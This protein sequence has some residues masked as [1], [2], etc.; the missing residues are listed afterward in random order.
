MKVLVTGA[1]GYIGGQI[2]LTC[3]DRGY[4]VIG[5]DWA[6][7]DRLSQHFDLYLGDF[8]DTDRFGAMIR[9]LGPDAVVHCAATSLVGPS[10]TDPADYY[11]NNIS[12]TVRLMDFMRVNRPASKFVFA[13]SASVYG[14]P[15]VEIIDESQPLRPISPYGR[16]KAAVDQACLDYGHAYGFNHCNLRFF[17]VAG[18]DA[19][20][21]HGQAPGATHIIARVLES[22]ADATKEF[23][24]NGN[25][26]QTPDG[27][28]IRDYVH[29][30]DVAD[31]AVAAIESDARGIFN[32]AGGQGFS[33]LEILSIAELV[34][35]TTLPRKFN[36]RRE[37]DPAKL[38]AANWKF[39]KATQWTPKRSIHAIVQD[40][41][42][43]YGIIR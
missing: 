43:W 30:E 14:Q 29:V 38:I 3:K 21:R 27:T 22:I 41:A 1:A 5:I 19:K 13:S 34:T 2:A 20:Q 11:Q 26:F 16:T 40:A 23:I 31:G 28:C 10:M 35:K 7:N 4:E 12:R 17:N 36:P 37:G 33:N 18:A 9:R 32:L 39:I 15:E 25:D 8:A 24:I 42:K 6:P